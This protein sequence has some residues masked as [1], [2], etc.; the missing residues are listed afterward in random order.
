MTKRTLA[1]TLHLRARER[2]RPIPGDVAYLHLLDLRDA[3]AAALTDATGSWLDF[4]SG[5]APYRQLIRSGTLLTSDLAGAEAHQTDILLGPDGT[6]PCPDEVFDGVLSTQVLEHVHDPEVHL[7]EALRVL[8]PGGRLVLS[9]HG[10]WEDHG[11]VDLWRWTD[12]GLVQTIVE[13][14]FVVDS[15]ERLTCDDRAVLLLLT[16]A[17]ARHRLP[18]RG[19]VGMFL[20]TLRAVDSWFAVL[21]RYAARHL[22]SDASSDGARLY[23]ALLAQAHRPDTADQ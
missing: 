7:A 8:R 19:V 15:V 6:I 22:H 2:M 18:V 9:T 20:L 11:E 1:E 3:L 13:A 4:G 16:R 10:I 23:I 14:G 5:S 12:D 17:L 21:D